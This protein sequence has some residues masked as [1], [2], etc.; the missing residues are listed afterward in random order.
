MTDADEELLNIES[1][2]DVGDLDTDDLPEP[3]EL[4][5]TQLGPLVELAK[6][7]LESVTAGEEN[8][9][10]GKLQALLHLVNLIQGV[11]TTRDTDELLDTIDLDELE[12]V[13][14]LDELPDALESGEL[15]DAVEL[16]NLKTLIEFG[17]LWD[18]V[19]LTEL[20]GSKDE[21]TE[22]VGQLTG[23]DD[24]EGGVLDSDLFDDMELDDLAG[25]DGMTG[26]LTDPETMQAATQAQLDDAIDGFR[27][28]LVET[29]ARLDSLREANKERFDGVDQPT[30][31]NPTAASTLSTHGG[32]PK[33]AAGVST[34]PRNVRH[35]TGPSRR[36]IY[37]RRFE[38]LI[39]KK[40]GDE[41]TDDGG[42]DG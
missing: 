5:L 24:G 41:Q 27:D 38:T 3:S 13:V 25:D 22:T 1:L 29:H 31:R 17:Q 21:I 10:A 6:S 18:A 39:A 19:D 8:P 2:D 14:D 33:A 7:T 30:S 32:P 26:E 34:V 40:R 15:G 12:S 20:M 42:D 23:D 28:L 36:R 35:S 16:K 9:S 37:G 4:E 11:L